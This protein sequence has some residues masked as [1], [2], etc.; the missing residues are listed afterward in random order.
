[1]S[2][3]RS[4]AIVKCQAAIKV[5]PKDKLSTPTHM[6]NNLVSLNVYD[7]QG[8]FAKGTADKTKK[9]K[10]VAAVNMSLEYD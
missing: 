6:P 4:V 8:K 7:V 2:T 9:K 3:R 10:K 5:E 1:M